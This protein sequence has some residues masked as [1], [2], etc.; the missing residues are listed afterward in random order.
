MQ[1]LGGEKLLRENP[2]QPQYQCCAADSPFSKL[3][4]SS[5]SAQRTL[6]LRVW[7]LGDPARVQVRDWFRL[8]AVF[9]IKQSTAYQL[10][11]GLL[12]FCR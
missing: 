2:L 1:P 9:F 5:V 10:P 7:G 8:Q 12:H 4:Q 11:V 3:C 6:K